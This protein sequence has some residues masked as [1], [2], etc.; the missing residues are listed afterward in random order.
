MKTSPKPI[1]IAGAVIIVLVM[2]PVIY[3]KIATSMADP[4][5]ITV[6]TPVSE[7]SSTTVNLDDIRVADKNDFNNCLFLEKDKFSYIQ[8]GKKEEI[9]YAEMNRELRNKLDLFQS[10][11]IKIICTPETDYKHIVSV[12]NFM[13]FNKIKSYELLKI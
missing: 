5:A 13:S 12:L 2:L 4:I 1:L 11:N 7:P 8:N 6:T 3:F 9:A 10:V